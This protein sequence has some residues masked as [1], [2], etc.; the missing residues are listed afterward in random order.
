MVLVDTS[1]WVSHLRRRE[2]RLVA[3]L[4]AFQVLTHPFVIGELALGN[5]RQ[6]LEILAYLAALP[7][8]EAVDAEHVLAFIERRHLAGSGLGYVDVHLL[9]AAALAG[10]SLWTEDRRLAAVARGLSLNYA[11]ARP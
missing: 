1:V 5:L 7:R 8:A 3:L 10:T 9:A 4:E 6:R 11:A 2:I